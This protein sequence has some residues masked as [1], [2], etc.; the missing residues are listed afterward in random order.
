MSVI[1]LSKLQNV[2]PEFIDSRLIPSA[3]ST[4]KWILGGATFVILKR[5]DD[6]VA[7]YSPTMKTMGLLND[8][9]QIDIEIAKGFINSAFEKSGRVTVFNFT[10]DKTDGE[11]LIGILEKYQD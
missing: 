4:M 9:N 7:Q 8:N 2:I 10:F 5:L 1:S 6:I 11:A 3:P